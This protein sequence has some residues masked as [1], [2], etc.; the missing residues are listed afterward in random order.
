MEISLQLS[1]LYR[2]FVSYLRRILLNSDNCVIMYQFWKLRL[3]F[4]SFHMQVLKIEHNNAH[5]FAY[6]THVCP[7]IQKAV[8]RALSFAFH[9]DMRCAA[10]IIISGFKLWELNLKFK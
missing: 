7:A 10:D 1:K 9:N 6:N 5:K 8:C 3:I 2:R 4:F